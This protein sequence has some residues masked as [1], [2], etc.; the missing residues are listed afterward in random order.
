[1]ARA[2]LEVRGHDQRDAAARLQPCDFFAVPVSLSDA[3]ENP[4]ERPL[5]KK[6][7]NRLTTVGIGPNGGDQKLRQLVFDP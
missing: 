5:G 4:A 3:D 6:G 7:V 1:M 2:G